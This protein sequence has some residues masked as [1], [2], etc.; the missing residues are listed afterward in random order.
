MPESGGRSEKEMKQLKQER[1]RTLKWAEM[2]R[3]EKKFFGPKAKYREKMINRIYKGIPDSV[4]GRVWSII[5]D[6]E[7]TKIEHKGTYQV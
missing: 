4:R 7:K 2:L 3:D 1:D 5:L 6:I